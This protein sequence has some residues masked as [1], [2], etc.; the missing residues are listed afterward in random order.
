MKN[1]QNINTEIVITELHKAFEIFNN[2]FFKGELKEPAI[3]IQSRGNRKNCLG[4]CT[5][6]K[7]WK[8]NET[9]EERYEINIVAEGLN[10][11]VYPVMGT[12]IHEM[13][14]LHCLQNGIKDVSRGGTYHNKKFKTIAEESGLSIEHDDKI[15]WSLTSLQPTTMDLIDNSNINK[16]AFN[17]A[18]LD[19]NVA[20][21]TTKKK[22]SVRKYTCPKCG[23]IIR[24]SKEV[25][26]ICGD[27]LEAGHG[28]FKFVCTDQPAE[29]PTAVEPVKALAEPVA[30]PVVA[31]P[32][33]EPVETVKLICADCGCVHHVAE[34]T[35]TCPECGGKLI[36]PADKVEEPVEEP[37]FFDWNNM[38]IRTILDM[39]TKE[40]YELGLGFCSV[41][42]IKIVI[43]ERMN[44]QWAKYTEGQKMVFSKNYLD[45][46]PF[47]EVVETIKHQFIHHYEYVAKGLK[48]NHKK[49][50]KAL[51][52]LIGISTE[53]LSVSH[54]PVR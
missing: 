20:S 35:E 50:F 48:C 8:N 19:G 4:W 42:D 1:N 29:E 39:A 10:R 54:K 37:K 28:A 31:E 17:L 46:T 34:G 47:E 5:V 7:V 21:K 33:A 14:H 22:S 32:V 53:V 9:Q 38:M 15:G 3:L 11:G 12:L 40:F 43:S 41:E 23:C 44:T 26:V 45:N 6:N 27:C 36:N 13:V 24:A 25:N 18:R 16:E 49:E 2:T 52:E 30:E 51:C